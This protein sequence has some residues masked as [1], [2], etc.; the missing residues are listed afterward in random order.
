VFQNESIRAHPQ[1]ITA[2]DFHPSHCSVFAFSSSKGCIRLADMRA[3][4]LCDTHA[5]AF[6]ATEPQVH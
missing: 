1:V 2:A 4:A 3:A 5:K 6:E